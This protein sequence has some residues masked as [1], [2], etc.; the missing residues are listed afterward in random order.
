MNSVIHPSLNSNVDEVADV[1]ALLRAARL[2]KGDNLRQVSNV[3]RIRYDYLEY[4]ENG[5]L[6][7]L[8]GTVYS[9]GFIRAYSEYLGLD[10]NEL[11]SKLKSENNVLTD[12]TKLVFPAIIPENGIPGGLVVLI[13][14]LIT[15]LGYCTWYWFSS[16]DVFVAENLTTIPK[17]ATV[18]VE[19]ASTQQPVAGANPLVEASS[20]VAATAKF[21]LQNY[22]NAERRTE[23]NAPAQASL[24]ATQEGLGSATAPETP[25]TLSRETIPSKPSRRI[26]EIVLVEPNK[27][28]SPAVSRTTDLDVPQK[29]PS[30]VQQI[31]KDETAE[32]R[33][34]IRSANIDFTP[35]SIEKAKAPKEITRNV[36]NDETLTP[37]RL[38]KPDPVQAAFDDSAPDTL[39]KLPERT[40]TE[41]AT[42]S[43]LDEKPREVN[44]IITP[45]L[46][47][48]VNLDVKNTSRITITARNTSW[49]QLRD[50]RTNRMILSKVLKKDQSY[51]IPDRP[52]LSLMTGNAG[53]LEIIVDGELV[54]DVG[55]LGEVRRKI[56]ME[57]ESLKSGQAVVE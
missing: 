5:R 36:V 21:P 7:D 28:I 49:I 43:V 23:I 19:T 37:S 51:Q 55:K 34:V 14:L 47:E 24:Q 56:L 32:D 12:N 46:D 42:L 27:V 29:Y 57:V 15:V 25:R 9:T 40:N 11:V 50:I 52:G 22:Q 53:A 30:A 10:G 13:G 39:S 3:L 1:G 44:K 16:P 48:D 17:V 54:P 38:T 4:I 35:S 20:A 41:V 45:I 33:L 6:D 31:P 8:P 2:R 18:K 26:E